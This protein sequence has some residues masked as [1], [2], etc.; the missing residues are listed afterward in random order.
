MTQCHTKT[1]LNHHPQFPIDVEFSADDISSDGGAILL[2]QAE[3]RLGICETIAELIPDD[4]A[5]ERIAHTRFEQLLQ[6]GIQIGLGYADQND[7]RWLRGDPLVKT[8]CDL[9]PDAPDLSS[10][11]TLSRFENA[12]DASAVLSMQWQLIFSWI[13]GLDPERTEIII[14]IDSSAFEGYGAQQELSFCGFHRCHMLHPLLIFDDEDGQ[15]ITTILRPGKVHDAKGAVEWIRH[16][17]MC[18]KAL[19]RADCSVLVRADGGF[20]SPPMYRCLEELDQT[21][22]HVSYLLGLP[23]NSVLEAELKPVME[24]A[25][26]R[27]KATEKPARIFCDFSYR[28][29]SWQRPRHVIGKAEVTLLGDNPRFIV[30]NLAEFSARTL[31]EVGYCGRGRCE[32]Y[33]KEFKGALQGDRISCS[34]FNANGFRL[35]LHAVAYRLLFEIRRV[36]AEKVCPE[37]LNVEGLSQDDLS[38]EQIDHARVT[39]GQARWLARASFETLRLRLLK[40]ALVVR[41]TA[42][43]IY[44]QGARSF[45]M[46]ELFQGVARA[47]S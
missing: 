12:P 33:I 23:R 25:R 27:R 28:A 4:R 24:R 42:R 39:A 32:Q 15:L 5:S 36:I 14:D 7:A 16:L 19:H 17:I 46:A 18:L 47:M 8:A 26:A 3:T 29:G 13:R 45:P 11:P 22:G 1:R 35:I 38:A 34:D 21:W 31:Y 37:N 6:R 2:R 9:V 43:R 30:T 41:Q 40:V 20:A 10:Q 44:L